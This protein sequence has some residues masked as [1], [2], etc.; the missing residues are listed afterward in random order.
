VVIKRYAGVGARTRRGVERACLAH[1][2][3]CVPVPDVV[4]HDRPGELA[5]SFVAGHHGQDLLD[6][7]YG[8]LVLGLCGSVL[9]R[10]QRIDAVM[11]AEIPGRGPHLVHGDFGPQ[12]ILFDLDRQ[13]VAAVLDWEF[14]HR[15]DVIED[16]AWA[17]WIVRMHHPD[18]QGDLVHLFDG[19]GRCPTWEDRLEQMVSRCEDLV[20]FAHRQ[21]WSEAAQMWRDRAAVTQRWRE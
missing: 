10:L 3:G 11:P 18:R 2:R 4:A 1:V 21:G 17:E 20:R 6:Q 5:L 13:E 19:F 14:A 15:G 8:P 9:A 12:N 16:L 7:G